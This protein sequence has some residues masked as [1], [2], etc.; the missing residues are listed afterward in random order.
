M[1]LRISVLWVGSPCLVV[2]NFALCA[3][4]F[5]AGFYS[6]DFIFEMVFESWSWSVVPCFSAKECRPTFSMEM[7]TAT[8]YQETVEQFIALLEGEQ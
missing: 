6:R 5:L 7:V 4:P 1:I 3:M 8:G 2:S